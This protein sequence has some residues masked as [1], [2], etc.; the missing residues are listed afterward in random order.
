MK[1]YLFVFTLFVAALGLTG[2][3]SDSNVSISDI[4][5]EN[6]DG[7]TGFWKLVGYSSD[8]NF[9]NLQG[10]ESR[11]YI[12]LNKKGHIEA[13]LS[14]FFVG[15]YEYDEQGRFTILES[16]LSG[17]GSNSSNSDI[18]FIEEQIFPSKTLSYKVD[19]ESLKLFYSST[20]YILFKR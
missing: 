14:H 1:K 16:Q 10:Y 11:S 3:S 6:E 4:D 15:K 13:D 19:K 17:D 18:I 12:I 2:C 8:G 5:V 7:I 20:D 9:V